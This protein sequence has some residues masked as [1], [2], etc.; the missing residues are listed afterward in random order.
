[1]SVT[2]S[3]TEVMGERLSEF[4][5]LLIIPKILPSDGARLDCPHFCGKPVITVSGLVR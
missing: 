3:K 4:K 2:R 1:M 5:C